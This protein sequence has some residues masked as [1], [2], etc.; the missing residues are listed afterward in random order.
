MTNAPFNATDPHPRQRVAVLDT[1]ISDVDT[2][3]GDTL[4]YSFTET[5]PLAD[6]VVRQTTI[7]AAKC[8]ACE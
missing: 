5:S 2:S 8:P 7:T 3:Q 6:F 1:E 4:S